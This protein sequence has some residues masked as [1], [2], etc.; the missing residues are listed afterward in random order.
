MLLSLYKKCQLCLSAMMKTVHVC[1]GPRGRPAIELQCGEGEVIV[2]QESVVGWSSQ[3]SYIDNQCPRDREECTAQF[4]LVVQRCQG[5]QQCTVLNSEIGT[6][7]HKPQQCSGE[8]NYFDGS[9][10]C[11]S[12]KWN[13]YSVGKIKISS[14]ITHT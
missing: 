6:D 2:V 3:H 1:Y 12:G 5:L 4:D 9:Y 8:T 10:L 7:L 14:V 11:Q 13:I